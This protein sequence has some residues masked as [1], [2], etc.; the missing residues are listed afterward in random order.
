MILVDLAGF[1]FGV[2]DDEDSLNIQGYD[3]ETSPQFDLFVGDRVNT[4]RGKVVGP[5]RQTLS[6][7]GQT[8]AAS[9]GVMGFGFATACTFGNADA[10]DVF[11]VTTGD[12]LMDKAQLSA[13]F[14]GLKTF[15]GNFSRDSEITVAA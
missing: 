4:N 11:G 3:L 8:T 13:K 5:P 7:T 14:D 9:G 2:E 1:T 12:W 15:T 10:F 6:L